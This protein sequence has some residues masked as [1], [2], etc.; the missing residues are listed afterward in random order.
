[1]ALQGGGAHGAFTW[2]V[3]DC[4]L[5]DGRFEIDGISGTSAGAMNAVCLADGYQAGGAEKARERLAAFWDAIGLA[6]RFSP[7]ARTPIDAWLGI[8]PTYNSPGQTFLEMMSRIYSPYDFNPLDINPLRSIVEENVNFDNVQACDALHLFI[9][10]TNV[11]N[12]KVRVFEREEITCAAV[13]ASSCLPYLFKAVEVD[14]VPYWDGGFMGNPVLFPFIYE[15]QTD[16]ILLIQINP[17]ERM[18]TPKTAREIAD[19]MNEITFNAS[20]LREFRAIQ[21]VKK[22]IREKK[23]SKDEYKDL[24]LHR[25]AAPTELVSLSASTKMNSEPAFL[26]HLYKMGCESAKQ[27]LDT[28]AEKVGVEMGMN[29]GEEIAYGLSDNLPDG[30]PE[31]AQAEIRRGQ[32][33]SRMRKSGD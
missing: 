11:W 14:G 31:E 33:I 8:W 25:I 15:T 1:M 22:L 4:L 30:M 7:P 20:L 26:N 3:L 28:D 21:F 23:V 9:A 32:R 6:S 29:L 19:R 2:G 16:D 10:A 5:E 24:R 12:G 13:M 17:V 27:W 18:E